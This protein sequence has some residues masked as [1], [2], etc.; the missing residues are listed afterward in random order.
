MTRSF[1]LR[2]TDRLIDRY[3]ALVC[4]LDGVVYRGKRAVVGAV[5]T[6]TTATALGVRVVFATNNA[7]RTPA[8][9]VA[10]LESLGLVKQIEPTL[11]MSVVT[12][13]EAA[14]CLVKRQVGPGSPVLAVGG[15]GV[16]EALL[17][18]ELVAFS[19]ADSKLFPEALA[20]VQG[21]G[22]D[23]TWRD[24][25]EA[26][27]RIQQGALWVATNQ[28]MTIPT[29][30]GLAPG[31]GAFAEAV[32]AAVGVE[33]QFAGKPAPALYELALE[34]VAVSHEHALVVGDRLDTD[35]AGAIA[36]GLDSLVVLSGAHGLADLVHCARDS[37]PTYLGMDL[38]ALLTNPPSNEEGPIDP[39]D[40]DRGTLALPVTHSTHPA[41]LLER[42][43]R[44][45][46]ATLDG[47]GELPHRADAWRSME[48]EIRSA[49]CRWWDHEFG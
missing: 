35:I 42:V 37:R 23:V 45:A 1:D 8:D 6:L 4:D 17:A 14:A 32:R 21:A 41:H 11:S 27:Y 34:R 36:V 10:H 2:Q 24:L 30:R 25:A 16:S 49:W 19:S 43:V 3:H 9:V 15:P 38:R 33:A 18:A 7:S 48:D 12:S 47:G 29:S 39:L 44:A 22:H 46:W 28:D 40:F 13:A 31:N 20:V 26:A 5:E